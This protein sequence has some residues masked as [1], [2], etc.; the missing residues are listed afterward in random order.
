M[1]NIVSEKANFRSNKIPIWI[2][3]LNILV[4]MIL[5]FQLISIF[6]NPSWAYGSFDSSLDVNHQVILFLGGRN[7]VMIVV[8]VLA[9]LSQN[10]MFL[11]FTY[12]MNIVRE[13]YDTFVFAYFN[14]VTSVKSI[15]N[16][17]VFILV[18][19]IPYYIALKKLRKLAAE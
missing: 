8:I 5:S 11:F 15:I 1:E 13:V 19:I 17:L 12:L 9:L 3:A 18:F 7:L 4:V 14:G 16:I 2:N 10:A 6:I